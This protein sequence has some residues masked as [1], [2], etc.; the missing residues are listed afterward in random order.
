MNTHGTEFVDAVSYTATRKIDKGNSLQRAFSVLLFTV[1]VVVDLLAL[2][3]GASSYGSLAKMQNT[4]DT[5]VMSL[6]PIISSVR[7][8]DA[9]GAVGRSSD[10]PEGEALVLTQTDELGAY[11][12]RIYLYQGKIMQEFALEGAPYAPQ[13]ATALADSSTFTFSYDDGVLTIAT[14]AGQCKIALRNQ[15]G[16]A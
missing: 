8:N 10:A 3:A 6:G 13:K 2:A 14:D 1:F 9:N 11:E 4:N 15:Q 16:G 12:T 7:A 5:R